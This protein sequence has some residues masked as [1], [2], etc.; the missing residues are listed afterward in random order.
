MLDRT[1]P[2]VFQPIRHVAV[3]QT[4]SLA[5]GNGLRLH[6][7]NAGEQ[8]VIRLEYI[9]TAGTWYEPQ[10]GVSYFTAKMLPEGT[11]RRSAS[12]ISEFVDQ[13][14]SFLEVNQTA[15]RINLTVYT[16][17][18]HLPALLPLMEEV[19]HEAAFPEHE[20]DNLKNITRQNLRVN[21]QKNAYVAQH[22]F[23]EVVF[24]EN[25]PYGKHN[26]E[27]DIAAVG[28]DTLAAF[29]QHAVVGHAF[30]LVVS[31]EVSGETLRLLETHLERFAVSQPALPRPE[32]HP[33]TA[34]T[35]MERI[36]RIGSVQSSVRV[37]KRLVQPD[38]QPFTR[39]SPDYFRL[40][41]FNEILGGYFGSRLMKNIREEKGYTYGVFS[42]LGTFRQEGFLVI[43]SDVKK[44]FANQT[45][46]EIRKEIKALCTEPVPADELDTVKNYLLG[47]FAG[48]VTT[49]F[50]LADHFKTIYFDGLDYGFFDRYVAAIANTTT[51]ELLETGQQYFGN[52]NLTEVV[53]G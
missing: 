8:P 3:A 24:G 21:L 16:L 13:F 48:S 40:V 11:R 53:V 45:L 12:E 34:A 25:H 30:D 36:E 29:Y 43:G 49:P 14:G 32:R 41:V 39:R 10:R 2:P 17:A 5:L 15:E 37:G 22:R 9:F 50:S 18:K 33:E 26:R 28:H 20:L 27:E 19:L 6:W 44:E 52:D 46:D 38:G 51:E 47:A 1:Q 7:L 4:Q 31:G 42:S 23:R 35:Q